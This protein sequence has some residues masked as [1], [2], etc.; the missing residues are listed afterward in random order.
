MALGRSRVD[1]MSESGGGL[2]R[3]RVRPRRVIRDEDIALV[4]Y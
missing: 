2:I 1:S 3:T 4:A